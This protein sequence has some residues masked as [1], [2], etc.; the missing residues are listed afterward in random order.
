[1]SFLSFKLVIDK[2]YQTHYDFFQTITVAMRQNIT[3][4]LIG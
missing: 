3:T 2:T 1:M 4:T